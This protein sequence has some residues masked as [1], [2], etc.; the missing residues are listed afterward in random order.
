MGV[1]VGMSCRLS[2]AK[3]QNFRKVFDNFSREV[4]LF[5]LASIEKI[6]AA[7]DEWNLRTEY[8]YAERQW[9]MVFDTEEDLTMFLLRWS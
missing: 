7:G 4:N 1:E 3:D 2:L 9:Y 5:K 8:V 6:R